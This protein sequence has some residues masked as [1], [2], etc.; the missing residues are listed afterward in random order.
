MFL[1]I[2]TTFVSSLHPMSLAEFTVR[3]ATE[4]DLSAI[5]DIYTATVPGRMVTADT[6]PVTVASRVT[7]FHAHNPRTR[8]LWVVL[9]GNR[10][11]AWLSFNSFY[12]RPAYNPT[13]EISLYVAETHR[14]RGLGRGLLKRAIAEAP[15]CE[16][17]NLLGFIWAHNLP[18]L[19]L[20]EAYGFE[21]WGHLPGVAILDGV[22][23]DLIIVGLRL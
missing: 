1:S 21:R 6:E 16:I 18:S 5:V 2:L 4:A 7:W 10:L 14:R 20:F 12:G 15:R 23:R 8:P 11:C 22:E 19:Q 13:A 17:R 9:E 3:D